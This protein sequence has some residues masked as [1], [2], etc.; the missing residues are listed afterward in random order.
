M[1]GQRFLPRPHRRLARRQPAHPQWIYLL[2][3]SCR[4][5]YPNNRINYITLVKIPDDMP[6]T[7]IAG[8]GA[9]SCIK[10]LYFSEKET[11]LR[12]LPLDAKQALIQWWDG[13]L[14]G[15]KSEPG[16]PLADEPQIVLGRSLPAQHIKWTKDIRLLYGRPKKRQKRIDARD[17]L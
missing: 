10:G 7:F 2:T 4:A 8:Y 14:A 16:G 5:G 15:D 1:A 12:D 9:S 17:D 11:P 3:T 13:Y 6:V